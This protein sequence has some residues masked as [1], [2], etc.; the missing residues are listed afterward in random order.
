MSQFQSSLDIFALVFRRQGMSIGYQTCL[1]DM[2]IELPYSITE[3]S[4]VLSLTFFQVILLQTY[5]I[6]SLFLLNFKLPEGSN[7]LEVCVEGFLCVR[8]VYHTIRSS[9]PTQQCIS[10]SCFQFLRLACGLL[11]SSEKKSLSILIYYILYPYV[12]IY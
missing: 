10:V 8:S 2:C 9:L 6:Y 5:F 11:N 4:F 1:L 7:F 12:N 3:L